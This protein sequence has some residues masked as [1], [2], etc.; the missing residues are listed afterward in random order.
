MEL[1]NENAGRRVIPFT[2]MLPGDAWLWSKYRDDDALLEKFKIFTEKKFETRRGFYGKTGDR[3]VIKNCSIIK[4]VW[5][6]SDAYLK[7]ANK[8]KKPHH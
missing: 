5:I 3:T 7:G 8:L 1:R 2:G 6:G 4:D